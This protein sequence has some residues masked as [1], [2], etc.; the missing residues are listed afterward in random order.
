MHHLLLGRGGIF[1]GVGSFLGTLLWR[2]PN[3][4]VMR[5]FLVSVARQRSVSNNREVFSLGFVLRTRCRGN[6]VLSVQPE[7]QKG[8]T[9]K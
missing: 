4:G 6:I 8:D 7:L 3:N 5:S 1:F 9:V 2:R